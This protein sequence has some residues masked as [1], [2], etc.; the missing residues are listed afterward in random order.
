MSL[1]TIG[2]FLKTLKPT[3]F[4]EIYSSDKKNHNVMC[5]LYRAQD[6]PVEIHHLF[7]SYVA[8]GTEKNVQYNPNNET[9]TSL[10]LMDA[11]DNIKD[12]NDSMNS[13]LAQNDV[14]R[15]KNKFIETAIEL[16]ELLIN[17]YKVNVKDNPLIKCKMRKISSYQKKLKP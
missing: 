13:V 1:I 3:Q 2:Q 12:A 9:I 4:I 10:I 15:V 8:S 17:E 6:V 11:Y 5:G 14:D 7:V 16:I